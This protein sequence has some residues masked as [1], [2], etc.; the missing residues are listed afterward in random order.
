LNSARGSVEGIMFLPYGKDDTEKQ[1]LQSFGNDSSDKYGVHAKGHRYKGADF[2]IR[3]TYDAEVPD[4]S[5]V[6]DEI[7]NSKDVLLDA[8]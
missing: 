1:C 8:A 3:L 4:L 2:F 6:M 5:R 7:N